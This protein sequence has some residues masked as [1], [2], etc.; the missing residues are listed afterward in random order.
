MSEKLRV[1]YSPAEDYILGNIERKWCEVEA[2][3]L[4]YLLHGAGYCLNN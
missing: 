3:L 2:Y 1:C 4:T